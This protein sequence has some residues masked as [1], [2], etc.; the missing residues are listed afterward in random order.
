[1][2][3]FWFD[4]AS[5]YSYVAAM[6]VEAECAR[7]GVK[8]EYRPFLLGPIFTELLGIKDSPFNLQPVRGR[9]MWRDIERLCQKHSL[10]WRRPSV[11]PRHSVLAARVACSAGSDAG[12][13]TRSI[14]L[15]N[16]AEDRDISD[17]GILRGIVESAGGNGARALD[18]A[19]GADVK[20]RLRAH[21]AE[22]QRLGIFGA[23]DFVVK[24]ELFFG[25][26][27]LEDAIAWA[28]RT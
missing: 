25:Q 9:Y 1:M 5:T 28:Q 24:G 20:A 21:T 6:R 14:F 16:F 19:Q 4:F 10:P 13:L 11:F 12:A 22:A 27:R 23:P 17:E 2:L 26:D 18:L 15:A 7:A 3:Q 8:V